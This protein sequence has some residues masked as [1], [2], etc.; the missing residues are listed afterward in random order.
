MC[1]ILLGIQTFKPMHLLR[2]EMQCVNIT[3]R[4][5]GERHD[6]TWP[7]ILQ[8]QINKD[9]RSPRTDRGVEM[10]E[11]LFFSVDLV[12]QQK[13]YDLQLFPTFCIHGD[14]V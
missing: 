6:L 2:F 7:E 8:K 13:D 5:L 3:V 9:N 10:S 11:L 4:Y 14:I 12:N 1:K